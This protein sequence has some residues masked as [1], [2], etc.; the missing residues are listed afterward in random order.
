MLT[1]KGAAARLGVSPTLIYA[2]CARKLLRHER[3]GFDR[4]KILIPEDA[5]DEYR[6]RRTVE[7]EVG[8]A[9][10][11]APD[12]GPAACKA[13]RRSPSRRHLSLD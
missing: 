1:V 13:V 5:L 10:D 2:L 6:L 9:A 3:H 12:L 8:A 7:A 4:G 11:T